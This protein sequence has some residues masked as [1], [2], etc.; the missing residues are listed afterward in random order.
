MR[1]L[2]LHPEDSFPGLE[3]VSTW[4]LIVDLGRAP[5]ST[6]EQWGREAGCRVISLYDFAE[7]IEDLRRVKSLLQFGMGQVVDQ[8]GIDWWD[9]SSLLIVDDLLRG[10]L[11]ARLAKE[12]GLGCHLYVSRPSS[13]AETLRRC[14]QGTLHNLEKGF[15]PISRRIWHYTEALSKLEVAQVTQVL[16][17]KLD[18]EHKIRKR[19]AWGR[20]KTRGPVTLL[21]SAY[22]NVSRMAVAYAAM[23]PEQGFL[24][25]CARKS[26]K[27]K[28]LP[29]NVRMASLDRYFDSAGSA[30]VASILQRWDALQARLLSAAED[31]A[32]ADAGGTLA[33]IP[34]LIRSGVA[35]RDAWNRVFEQ[36]EVTGC[37]STDDTAPDTRI[38]LV[39][40]KNRGIA[41]V[42][43]HHGAL[44]QR[45]AIK[46][47]HADFY[48]AK[49]EMERDYLARVCLVQPEKLVVGGPAPVADAL[50]P[51]VPSSAAS[52][53][54]FFTEPYQT[55]AWRSD[56]VY[57]DLLPRLCSLA[58]TCGLQLV[59]K[60]ASVRKR[61][62]YPPAASEVFVPI[63]RA[64][65]PRACG[66]DIVPT[67][68]KH[69]ICH[70]GAIHGR[71]GVLCPENSGVSVRLAAR[72]SRWVHRAICEIRHRLRIGFG[73]RNRGCSGITGEAESGV[74]CP[75]RPV[76]SD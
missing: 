61:Q 62:K 72:T 32:D 50:E 69:Q 25:V 35:V 73:V 23:L 2:L 59:F 20:S 41:A 5:L 45:M 17:D 60:F 76:A 21:P 10:L 64:C 14:T 54:V 74:S 26:G 47:H 36:E 33:R 29:A 58:K 4:D 12:I 66:T 51:I 68:A 43:C 3:L 57:R 40:A 30:E 6:Y 48:L 37:L 1:V 9:I 27:L 46:K 53:L 13:L 24:L 70:D 18:P 38:P 44:D 42:A 75:R 28:V 65:D 71:A 52:W 34:A 49:G 67:L 16:Q 39:L 56:E 11:V 15:Q 8:F 31:F 63:G 19:F 55:D 22:V 7:E